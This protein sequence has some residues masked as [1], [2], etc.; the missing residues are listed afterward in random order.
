MDLPC[1]VDIASAAKCL[2]VYKTDKWKETVSSRQTWELQIVR[3]LSNFQAYE[4]EAT[5]FVLECR[6][7]QRQVVEEMLLSD[8]EHSQTPMSY[9]R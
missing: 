2:S 7:K 1:F 4:F 9:E 8:H 6:E 3:T 5:A